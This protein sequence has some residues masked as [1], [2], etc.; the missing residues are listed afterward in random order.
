MKNLIAVL[1]VVFLA[2][3][4][5]RNEESGS[6]Q[7]DQMINLYIDSANQDMLNA[8][9][10]GS[11]INIRMN[12]VYGITDNAP[13]SFN[14]KKD[15]DTISYIEYVA[16]AKRKLI[17]SSGNNK[18]Y[19]SKIALILTKKVNDT[20][21]ISNDTMTINYSFSPALFQVS[22]IWYNGILKFTKVDGQPNIV[23]ITK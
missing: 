23:K 13:V 6:Q 9:I 2:F 12:D 10:P 17:D 15:A 4:S 21:R 18:T 11:Y 19:Q 16:G 1:L 14:P 8:K 7:I 3:L 5:C 20:N 22:K